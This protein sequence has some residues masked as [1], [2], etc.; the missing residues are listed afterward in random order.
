MDSRYVRKIRRGVKM[1]RLRM[2]A[3]N[4]YETC[5]Y[6]CK[7]E[8]GV[9]GTPPPPSV[10]E[11]KFYAEYG[12]LIHDLFDKFA[13]GDIKTQEEMELEY[14]IGSG[15]ILGEPVGKKTK[16]EFIEEGYRHIDWFFEKWSAIPPLFTEKSFEGL[17]IEGI[18]EEFTGTVDRAVGNTESK[19]VELQDWKTGSSKKYTKKEMAHNIQATVYSLWFYKEYGFYPKKFTFIFTAERRTKSINITEEFISKGLL[20]IKGIYELMKQDVWLTNKNKFF[21]DNFCQFQEECPAFPL[22]DDKKKSGWDIC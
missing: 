6:K 17:K 19:D 18:D 7:K 15:K 14:K 9:L 8:F 16:A 10:E 4:C 13:K 3:L 2:S 22:K 5:P 20:R 21:C 11:E 1:E 12:I